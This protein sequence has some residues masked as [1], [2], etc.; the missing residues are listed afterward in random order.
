MEGPVPNFIPRPQ[1]PTGLAEL[2]A[3]LRAQSG[4][5]IGRGLAGIGEGIGDAV[6]NSRLAGQKADAVGA[7]ERTKLA[8]HLFNL[9]EKGLVS[10]SDGQPLTAELLYR[11]MGMKAP[12]IA[13]GMAN[14]RIDKPAPKAAPV[15]DEVLSP[16]ERTILATKL[17][18]KPSDLEGVTR[19]MA[20]V[21]LP[22][23]EAGAKAPPG[24]RFKADGSLE[25]IAG[26][27]AAQKIETADEKELKMRE[28]A[29]AQADRVIA[30]AK[31]S[32]KKV[33]ATTAGI[34]GALMKKVP[35]STAKDLDSLLLTIKANLGF[36]ELQAMRQASPT[37]GALGQVAVQEL[38]ALQ[39]TVAALDQEQ[40]PPQLKK[41]INDIVTHYEKWRSAVAEAGLPEKKAPGKKETA[42]KKGDSLDQKIDSFFAEKK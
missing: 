30:T 13:P 33:G 31:E 8:D 1:L 2:V 36:A 15:K 9:A 40:S 18:L 24:Y 38:Q 22:K 34:G 14:L 6:Q 10:T 3:Q 5:A 11:S 21:L 35:G 28:G 42:G 29:I 17:K 20:K 23:D 7:A 41:H 39:S 26:G 27:P 12:Q 37:G 25:A 32:L 16:Q 19:E 4:Q